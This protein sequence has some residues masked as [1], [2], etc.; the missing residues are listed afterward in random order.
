[1]PFFRLYNETL[2]EWIKTEALALGFS[3]CGISNAEELTDDAQRMEQWLEKGMQGEM[4]YLERNREKRYDVRKLVPEARSVI[5]VLFNYNP[6]DN[7]LEKAPYKIAK[8]AYGKDYHYVIKDKLKLLLNKIEERTGERKASAFTDSAPLMD[9]ALARKSGLGFVGKNT[10]LIN[11]KLGSYLFIGHLVID[12][13]LSVDEETT[14]NFCGS[15]TK[16][17]QACPTNALQPFELD[18]RK[19]ISY[20]TIEYR[21]DN[22]HDNIQPEKM[23][24][25]IFGCDICQDVCPWNRKVPTHNE[26]LFRPTEQLKNMNREDWINLDKATFKVLFKNSAVERTGLKGLKRN[27]SFLDKNNL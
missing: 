10:M 9:R 26:K 13:D 24:K 17:I 6:E 19:C 4:T 11:R 2:S 18:S 8:Y 21:G 25:W 14:V 20:L 15:C 7:S 23:L 3:A 1:M 22:L 12:L 16:C 5:T 27:I